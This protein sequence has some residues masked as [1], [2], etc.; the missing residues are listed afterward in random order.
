MDLRSKDKIPDK[1]IP[2]IRLSLTRSMGTVIDQNGRRCKIRQCRSKLMNDIKSSQQPFRHQFPAKD[3]EKAWGDDEEEL[4]KK[5]K[6]MQENKENTTELLQ[7]IPSG[8][9]CVASTLQL[10]LRYTAMKIFRGHEGHSEKS[11]QIFL[12]HNDNT[13]VMWLRNTQLSKFMM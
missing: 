10:L 5:L 12:N 13:C 9:C 3:L 8:K 6:M 2:R 4:K 7:D 11:C 1:P